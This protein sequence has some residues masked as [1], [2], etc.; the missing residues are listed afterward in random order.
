MK[1]IKILLNCGINLIKNKIIKSEKTDIYQECDKTL[2]FNKNLQETDEVQ[3]EEY[4]N[5]Y[6]STTRWQT[7]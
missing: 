3:V 7:V 4:L 2:V 6:S 1:K 5:N